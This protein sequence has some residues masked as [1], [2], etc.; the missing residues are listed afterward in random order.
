MLI[1]AAL[2]L[3]LALA[4]V[5]GAEVVPLWGRWER[6]FTAGASTSPET[7]FTVAMTAPSGQTRT[8]DG[9][10]DGDQTWR[11]RFMP[12]E[13]GEWLYR[14]SATPSAAG[15]EGVTGA[16]T[17]RRATARGRFL[18]HGAVRVAESGT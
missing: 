3:L 18:E 2:V 9:Y 16:F 1:T 13:E 11:V 4:V 14:A 6:A 8:L 17:C 5:A 7:E 10:W 12:D 15:L